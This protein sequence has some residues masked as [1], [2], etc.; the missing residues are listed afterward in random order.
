[1]L[2]SVFRN[3]ALLSLFFRTSL[4]RDAAYRADFLLRMFTATLQMC[5]ELL[6][7]W[8]IFANTRTLAGWSAAQVVVLLGVYRLMIGLIGMVI[9]PNMRLIMEDIRAGTLDFVLAKPVN[10][11][12]YVSFRNFVIWRVNDLVLGLLLV[13]GG[14]TVLGRAG[15]PVGVAL[16]VV[17]AASAATII[18]SL[19]LMLATSVFWFVRVNNI[20][21]VFWNAF[22]ASRYPVDIYRPWV[23]WALTFLL[24]LAFI[25]T[26]PAGVLTGQTRG[27]VV[28][29]GVLMAPLTLALASWFWRFGLRHYSGAS[30]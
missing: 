18:Y 20:E 8:T 1:M 26:F 12:F 23:R 24:P 9:A 29:A 6:G 25:T 13:G 7:L 5:G 2:S 4:Q 14:V 17:M 16:F 22:E 11:Q 21:M 10:C 28:W 15:D 3:L 27:P 19:W 30:A